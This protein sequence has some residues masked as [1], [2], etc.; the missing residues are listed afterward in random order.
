MRS[1]PAALKARQQ[2]MTDFPDCQKSRHRNFRRGIQWPDEP[3]KVLS[4]R[5]QSAGCRVRRKTLSLSP[6][7]V[8]ACQLR[9]SNPPRPA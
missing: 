4:G 3:Q 7:V 1:Y 9:S 5:R 2:M 6:A 8:P